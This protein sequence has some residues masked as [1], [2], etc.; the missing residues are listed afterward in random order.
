MDTAKNHA[1][2][3]AFL[4]V[5]AGQCGYCLS[6]ILISANALL[7]HTPDPTWAQICHPS[8]Q[9]FKDTGLNLIEIYCHLRF[10]TWNKECSLCI[11]LELSLPTILKWSRCDQN[12]SQKDFSFFHICFVCPIILGADSSMAY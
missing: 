7:Q 2:Q 9:E 5:N 6:G 8:S 3:H 1:L 10:T 11:S 4:E 12:Q